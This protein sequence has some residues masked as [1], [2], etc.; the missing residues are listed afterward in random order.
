MPLKSAAI[1]SA[2]AMLVT[3]TVSAAANQ[4]ERVPKPTSA[5]VEV[6]IFGVYHFANP[7]QDVVNLE[8]D[9][10]LAPRRQQEIAVLV[11]RLGEWQPTKIAV[12]DEAEAPLF[13]VHSYANADQLL[14]TK[15]SESVQ[16]G[17]RLA[18]KLGHPH[19]YG[20]DE[21]G[22]EGE[23]DYFPLGKVQDFATE[24]GQAQI[25]TD[26]FAEVQTVVDEEARQL[27][28]QTVAQSLL[29]HNR[30]DT[31][32]AMHDR[33]YYSMLAIGDGE[34]QPGAELNAYWYMRNAKMFAKI[35]M[36]AKPGDRVL[37]LAGSGHTTWL[38]HFVRHTPGF[39]LVD[40]LPIVQ[41]AANDT[42]AAEQAG[43]R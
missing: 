7:G 19:V 12:E 25:L 31:L 5:D 11:E 15:R 40:A 39:T 35:G 21:R 1:L 14:R 32:G 36:I 34:R 23:P 3:S 2:V 6:M 4:G 13:H 42:T 29:S 10:F 37:V 41:A 27:P 9:D 20:Y 17:Y 33:I 16:I 30:E 18:R 24:N 26:L 43:S 8:V 38:K 22:G 28:S